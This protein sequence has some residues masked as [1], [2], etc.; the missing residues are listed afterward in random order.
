MALPQEISGLLETQAYLK[1]Q[2]ATAELALDEAT[3]RL[4]NVKRQVKAQA[5]QAS[6]L[7][8]SS[9]FIQE[10]RNEIV[11]LEADLAVD[12]H[13]YG[14]QHRVVLQKRIKLAEAK[15]QLKQEIDRELKALHQGIAPEVT[16]L[17]T[18][19]VAADAQLAG[20][21]EILGDL[22]RKLEGFP[23]RQVELGRLQRQVATQISLATILTEEHE[24]ARILEDREALFF[25]VVDPAVP[26]DRK[27]KPHRL[28]NM[29]IAGLLG[30]LL[31]TMA[32]LWRDSKELI[33]TFAGKIS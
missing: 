9:P 28:L 24:K 33:P 20:V 23:P 17:E 32:A 8:A 6:V 31:G 29:V 26:P 13:T 2:Q 15:K 21:N 16:D 30:L 19:R 3:T 25:Q 7:P 11:K 12:T 18:E 10:W 5:A 27:A 22:G 4:S 14:P 1:R